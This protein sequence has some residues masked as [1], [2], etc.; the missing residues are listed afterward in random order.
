MLFL[1]IVLLSY[2]EQRYLYSRCVLPIYKQILLT[3]PHKL[4]LVFAIVLQL[5]PYILFT[6]GFVF[7]TFVIL[8][9]HIN[10]SI[11]FK[12]FNTINECGGKLPGCCYN[13]LC[14]CG[15]NPLNLSPDYGVFIDELNLGKDMCMGGFYINVGDTEKRTEVPDLPGKAV[16]CYIPK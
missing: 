10:S 3:F 16:R 9:F 4:R 12:S 7:D 2:C 8:N 1:F 5:Y 6:L 14:C 15:L 11:M 13:V